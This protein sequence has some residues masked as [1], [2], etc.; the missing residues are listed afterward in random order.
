MTRGKDV[1]LIEFLTC[2][3]PGMTA[4]EEPMRKASF[5]FI[6]V[7]VLAAAA[8]PQT[9]PTNS[10]KKKPARS[11]NFAAE[12]EKLRNTWVE[13]FNAKHA[14]KVAALYAPEAVLMR[15]DGTVHGYDS[16]LADLEKSI[17][18]GAHDYTVHSLHVES[19]GDLGFDTGAYNVGL[20]DRTIEGNY[21]FVV[22]RIK[23]KWLIVA[24]AHV[25]N[26]GIR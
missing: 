23:G 8:I 4:S 16:I 1:G 13:E 2:G 18:G 5:I 25:P 3:Y 24:H 9:K 15:W 21:V 6:A 20:T 7:L 19:S 26:P 12:M 17:R 11:E 22:K 14:D 10:S